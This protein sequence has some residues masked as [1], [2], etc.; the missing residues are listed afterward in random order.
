MPRRPYFVEFPS[1]AAARACFESPAY[2]GAIALRAGAAHFDIVVV[3]G[4]A[5]VR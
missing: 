3:E 2:Q 4:L 1:Y 5:P